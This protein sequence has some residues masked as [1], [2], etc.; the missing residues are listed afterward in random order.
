MT[1]P[2]EPHQDVA[3]CIYRVHAEVL[4][5]T[6]RAAVL[7]SINV[8]DREEG[9][10]DNHRCPDGAVILPE[11]AGHWIGE[12]RAAFLGGPD[13]IL[14]VLSEADETYL[15]FP[16]Y[17]ARG[18]REILIVDSESR[19]PELWRREASGFR[20]VAPPLRSLVTGLVYAQVAGAVE[21]R[22]PASGKVWR[23]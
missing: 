23:V 9:R 11:N 8:T 1:D 3:G 16:F 21:I 20:A 12:R 18:V 14:E 10:R 4:R 19:R 22:D 6:E 5:D 17:E 7:I 2:T 13:L 15:K